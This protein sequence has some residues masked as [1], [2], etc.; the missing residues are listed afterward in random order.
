MH[1]VSTKLP[2]DQRERLLKSF[3]LDSRARLPLRLI[4]VD[5]DKVLCTRNP[6]VAGSK[7]A[8][9]VLNVNGLQIDC[10]VGRELFSFISIQRLS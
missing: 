5:V 8:N 3:I 10:L 6:G 7:L 4:I 2:I 9:L 1:D